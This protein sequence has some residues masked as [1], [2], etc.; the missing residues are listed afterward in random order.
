MGDSP[1]VDRG[2]LCDQMKSDYN[3]MNSSGNQEV[4]IG[5]IMILARFHL[6]FEKQNTN[7]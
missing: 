7:R 6:I 2:K 4:R 3:H 5:M 1:D